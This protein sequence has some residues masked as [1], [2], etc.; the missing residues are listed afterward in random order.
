MIAYQP[1]RVGLT[2]WGRAHGIDAVNPF[3][4]CTHE[5]TFF[6]QLAFYVDVE[7]GRQSLQVMDE[8]SSWLHSNAL[9]E[10]I[11]VAMN[12]VDDCTTKIRLFAFSIDP[13]KLCLVKTMPWS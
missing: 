4:L 1:Q 2:F 3:V 7:G 8:C 13:P 11:G 5:C 12:S 9:G 6:S 10:F